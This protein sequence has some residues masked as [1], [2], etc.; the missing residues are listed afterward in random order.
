MNSAVYNFKRYEDSSLEYTGINR[1]VADENIGLFSTVISKDEYR[2]MATAQNASM[3][4]NPFKKKI[5]VEQPVQRSLTSKKIY[6]IPETLEQDNV[7]EETDNL[8]FKEIDLSKFRIGTVVRHTTF[9]KGK[10]TGIKTGKIM[11]SF[12]AT[13]KTLSFPMVIEKGLV[14]VEEW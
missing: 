4:E 9:G 10:V 11:V 14:T 12:A 1:H 7:S 6:T 13:N 3:Q 8:T 2:E 5:I